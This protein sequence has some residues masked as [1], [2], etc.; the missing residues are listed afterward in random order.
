MKKA[1]V[2]LVCIIGMIML[3]SCSAHVPSGGELV[4][5]Q[6]VES[7]KTKCY[8]VQIYKEQK[9]VNSLAAI[10]PD[11]RM[12]V[13][14]M[15]QQGEFSKQM[16]AIATGRSLDPCTGTNLFDAQIAEVH[17]KNLTVR[18]STGKVIGVVPWIVGGLTIS[19]L[20]D[21]A[22]ESVVN[23]YNS[24][25]EVNSDSKNA[26]SYN[27]VSGDA[28]IDTSNT[29]TSSVDNSVDNSDNSDNSDNCK[30]GECDDGAGT[31]GDPS[32]DPVFDLSSCLANPPA[33][34]SSSGTPLWTS[35]CSCGSHKANKC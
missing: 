27:S 18:D 35:G 26:G 5:H 22:G 9:L 14:M 32:T 25:S 13:L 20:A 15:N 2:Y 3:T 19:A 33:G 8:E 24:G 11:Q 4:A 34:H 12:M 17:E 6:Q 28:A 7:S 30:E 29:I 21:N 31:T 10:P 23:S 16:L 1:G